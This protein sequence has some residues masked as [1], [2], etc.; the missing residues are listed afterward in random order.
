ME[1]LE[2]IPLGAAHSFRVGIDVG[3][4][5]ADIVHMNNPGARLAKK[6]SSTLEFAGSDSL[7]CQW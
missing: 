1:D 5:F 6:I 4:A 3:G 7:G 2:L